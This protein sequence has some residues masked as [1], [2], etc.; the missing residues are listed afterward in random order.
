MVWPFPSAQDDRL[1]SY[2]IF[3]FFAWHAQP[4]S[5]VFGIRLVLHD[6]L[7]RLGSAGRAIFNASPVDG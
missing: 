6:H 7:S 3:R 1:A 5:D 2:D 4:S